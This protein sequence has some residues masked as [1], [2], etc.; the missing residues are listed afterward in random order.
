MVYLNHVSL[1]AVGL[2]LHMN[3]NVHHQRFLESIGRTFAT[4]DVSVR[5]PTSQALVYLPTNYVHFDKKCIFSYTK[6]HNRSYA[7][8][9]IYFTAQSSIIED[10]SYPASI[11]LFKVN[12]RNNRTMPEICSK[13]S[14]GKQFIKLKLHNI[15]KKYNLAQIVL[16]MRQISLEPIQRFISIVRLELIFH[17]RF[18]SVLHL[19]SSSLAHLSLS[20]M[21]RPSN[22]NIQISSSSLNFKHDFCQ[23][24]KI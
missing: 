18:H 5:Q 13:T 23:Y 16:F 19:F 20:Y 8:H 10:V 6:Q 7:F 9:K 15:C 24:L 14:V 4:R 12:N 22:Q 3:K 1:H 17:K 21:T 11:Y 2:I